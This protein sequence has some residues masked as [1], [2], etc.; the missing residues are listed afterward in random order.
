MA[1]VLDPSGSISERQIFQSDVGATYAYNGWADPGTA[2]SAATWSIMRETIAT[3]IILQ[4]DGGA[5]TQIWNNRVS[6]T[7]A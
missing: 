5:F 6:L 7:Y 4:A 2:T 1:F 3:G